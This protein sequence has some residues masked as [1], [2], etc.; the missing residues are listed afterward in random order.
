MRILE[1]ENGLETEALAHDQLIM[2]WSHSQVFM[3]FPPESAFHL[4]FAHIFLSG[5]ENYFFSRVGISNN[6]ELSDHYM[7]ADVIA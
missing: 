7:T 4:P 3:A 6:F 2:M 1:R 5:I